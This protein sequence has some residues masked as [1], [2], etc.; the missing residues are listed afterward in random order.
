M[1]M[2]EK[3]W[4]DCREW[5]ENPSTNEWQ[6]A[7][8]ELFEEPDRVHENGKQ[9]QQVWVNALIEPS[10]SPKILDLGASS[11]GSLSLAV[12]SHQNKERLLEPLAQQFRSWQ[13]E[14]I[15]SFLICQQKEQAR[16]LAELLKGYNLEV[17][18]SSLPFGQESYESADV[19]V[20]VGPS[21]SYPKKKSLAEDR[22]AFHG[23]RYRAFF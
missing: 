23:S 19:K 14:G 8:A 5:A 2:A 11:H 7:P 16:R 21:R 20:L 12:K 3:Y 4:Q 18:F 17:L 13:E 6:K 10:D 15:R 9:F 22:V 1:D